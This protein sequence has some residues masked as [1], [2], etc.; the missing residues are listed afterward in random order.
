MSNTVRVDPSG[1]SVYWSLTI[2]HL[3]VASYRARLYD[4]NGAIIQKWDDQRTDD[5]LPDRFQIQA[6]PRN[7]SG[8]ILSW[9]AYV[10]DP[11]D[12]GGAYVGTVTVDQEGSVLC[13]ESSPGEV[14]QGNGKVSLFA[15]EIRFQ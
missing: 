10:M 2:S 12:K 3:M 14:P 9:D 4:S 13:V 6:Q 11:S 5:S 8:C 1:G 15:D 7:L